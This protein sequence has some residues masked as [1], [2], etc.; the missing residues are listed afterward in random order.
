MDGYNHLFSEALSTLHKRRIAAAHTGL[1]QSSSTKSKISSS[2]SGK[3]NFAGKRHS[4][5]SRIKIG[6]SRGH[7]DRVQGRKWRVDRSGKTTR[8][9]KLGSSADYKWGRVREMKTFKEFMLSEGKGLWDNI[10]AK[11]AR[12]A[13]GSGEKMRKPGSKGAPTKQNFVDA[14]K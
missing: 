7:D 9:Y 8:V 12:I 4:E 10:H 3:S 13:R 1:K 2:M 5:K 11:R 14:A 6:D